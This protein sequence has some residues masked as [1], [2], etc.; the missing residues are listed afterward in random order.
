M[1]EKERDTIFVETEGDELTD[2]ELAVIDGEPEPDPDPDKPE[3]KPED[4]PDEPKP[5][6]EGEGE[7]EGHK[8]DKDNLI[9]QAE[10]D[11]RTK[12]IRE[13]ADEK[14]NLFKNDKE[15]YY[16]QY[17]D[18]APVEPPV[19][20][21]WNILEVKDGPYDGKT[22]KEVYDVD[23]DEARRLE[24]SYNSSQKAEADAEEKSAL[25][26]SQKQVDALSVIV[27]EDMFSKSEGLTVAETTQVNQVVQE[28]LTFMDE[29]GRGGGI[30]LDAYHL[31]NRE[32]D[33]SKARADGAAALV[34]SVK[35][36]SVQRI[37]SD[38]APG[39]LSG[40]EADMAMDSDQL[41]DKI[42][43]M[44]DSAMVKYLAD[45]PDEMKKKYPDLPWPN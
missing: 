39:E 19:P 2:E 8:P 15:E 42:D 37:S 36:G 26:E 25:E 16:K 4:K 41:S 43:D 32:T 30:L 12:E 38:V 31:K 1:T 18:E 21:D 5:P 40:Y 44:S 33:Q 9:P 35:S 14:L 27:S 29:T 10:L 3:D 13:K 11:K 24:A 45:A 20:S 17:P 6:P 28:T 34:N 22:L 7:P 23:P